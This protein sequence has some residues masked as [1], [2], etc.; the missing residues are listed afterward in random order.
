MRFKLSDF[1]QK[2]LCIFLVF[3][4]MSCGNDKKVEVALLEKGISLDLA[5][6]RKRQ[7][8][9]IVYNLSFN[10]PREREIPIASQL[11]LEVNITDLEHLKSI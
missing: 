11:N 1:Y 9:D 5:T 2:L 4:M 3:S 10:I 8:E 7:V 6:Y